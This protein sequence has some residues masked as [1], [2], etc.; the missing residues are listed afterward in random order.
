MTET[1][2]LPRH[3]QRQAFVYIRQSSPAQVERNTESTRRIPSMRPGLIIR[4]SRRARAMRRQ[5]HSW[6]ESRICELR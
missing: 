1:G 6:S 3:R 5:N 2:I 4:A